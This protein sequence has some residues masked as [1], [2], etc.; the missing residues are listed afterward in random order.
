MKAII[1]SETFLFTYSLR[2]ILLIHLTI[3]IITDNEI[4]NVIHTKTLH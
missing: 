1:L 3:S 2:F 4:Q